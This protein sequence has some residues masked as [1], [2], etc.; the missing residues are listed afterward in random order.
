[1]GNINSDDNSHYYRI[2]VYP[3]AHLHISPIQKHS[4]WFGAFILRI[5]LLTLLSTASIA[6]A[7]EPLNTDDAGTVKMD[8]NQIEQYFFSIQRHGSTSATPIDIIT[9]GEEFIGS[10]SAKALPF[11]YTRGLR[12]NLE[13]SIATTFYTEPTGSYSRFSNSV[14]GLKWRFLE[15]EKNR[16]AVAIKPTLVLP[17]STQQQIYGL[18]LAAPNYGVN[19][20]TSKYWY[21]LEVHINAAYMRS[22]YNTNYVVGQ[23]TDPNRINIFTISIAP[24]WTIHPKFKVALDIGANT[25]P[26]KPEQYLSNYI[27]AAL[28]FSPVGEIDI[29][30]SAM[31]NAFN[32][33]VALSGN[34][35]NATRTE[36]GL[37]WRF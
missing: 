9:P 32:Y 13:A 17:A 31:R 14:I 26:P 12:D 33:G 20:I 34:G 5:F 7:F 16:Y 21:D 2:L 28:I 22:P 11:T 23:S 15:D 35:P 10:N 8:M 6:V 24:V 19:F 36:I 4:L 27:L 3:S 25:N 30:L 37:T 18:G 29:G 1:L